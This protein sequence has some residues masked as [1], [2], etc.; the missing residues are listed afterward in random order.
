MRP[1]YF[2][3]RYPGLSSRTGWRRQAARQFLELVGAG[4]PLVLLHGGVS[5]GEIFDP[6]L[7]VLAAKRQVIAVHLQGHGCTADIDRPLRFESMAEDIAALLKLLG[8]P[9]ADILGYSLGGGVALQMAIHHPELLRKLVLVSTPFKRQGFYPEV[10]ENMGQ[11]GPEAARFMDRAPVSQLYPGKDWAALFTK[12]GDLL[13]QE[14][15]WSK[16]VAAIKL[17]VML[18]HADADSVS[19]GH[20]MEFFM[21]LGGGQRD[22]AMDGSG[23]RGVWPSCRG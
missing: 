3:L 8:L 10:L 23:R 14:Y 22:A 6:L 12:L 20:A 5:A 7:A 18:V 16:G 1:V 9:G 4:R 19:S 13:R 15:D 17:P 11:M 2:Y 21:L